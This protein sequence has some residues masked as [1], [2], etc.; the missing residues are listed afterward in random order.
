[1]YQ[2]NILGLKEAQEA[3]QVMIKEVESKPDQYWQH[4]CFAVVDFTG[5]LVAF[6]RMDGAHAQGVFMAMRKA[7]TA[8]IWG[9]SIVDFC[10]TIYKPP[11][12]LLSFGTEF[13]FSRGGEPILTRAAKKVK[14]SYKM[15]Y[16]VGGI[17]VGNVGIGEVD[18]AIAKI[19]VK[20]LES[21]LWPSE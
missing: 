11:M 6:A 10:T 17:G 14:V 16:C 2:R 20:Y 15:P 21:V 19:G 7:Y 1:M 8:A 12:D 4:G 13:T 3:I 9:K 18:E 5:T